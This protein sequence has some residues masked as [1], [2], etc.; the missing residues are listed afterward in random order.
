[1]KVTSTKIQNVQHLKNQSDHND[2]DQLSMVVL[3]SGSRGNAY[4]IWN[5]DTAVLIDCGLSTKQIMLRLEAIGILHPQIDAI[6][7]THEHTDHVSSCAIL[8]KRLNRLG[9]SPIFYMSPGTFCAAP[10]RCL[11]KEVSLIRDQ[12]VIQVGSVMVE[13]FEVP[14][15]GTECLGYRVGYNGHWVGVITDLGDVTDVVIDKMRTMTTMAFEFNHDV[16]MLQ[17]GSYPLQVQERILDWSGH[18][19]NEQAAAALE[20]SISP[21]LQN[22]ILAHISEQNNCP[23]LA[24]SIAQNVLDRSSHT[25]LIHL[26]VAE[27]HKPSPIF[28]VHQ[29]PKAVLS[30]ALI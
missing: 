22:L 16:E 29:A 2:P 4:Y 1:M 14:H 8:E 26:H 13:A 5:R 15:D 28:T 30:T 23:K 7:I 12:D 20:R 6:F 18:L 3:G 17:N 11:P 9:Q 19:S 24:E 27:Q 10:E 21:R 25:D